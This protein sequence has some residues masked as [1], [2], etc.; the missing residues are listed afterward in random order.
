M[1][2]QEILEK[3][4]KENQKHDE[5]E[6]AALARAGQIAASVGGLVCAVILVLEA[7]LSSFNSRVVFSI[8]AVYLAITGTTL[9]VKYIKLHKKHELIFG[10]FQLALAALF[11][12]MYVIKLV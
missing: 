4:R 5:R 12:I 7:S 9:L 2:K 1:N 8:W 11:F 10:A 3:S 6:L